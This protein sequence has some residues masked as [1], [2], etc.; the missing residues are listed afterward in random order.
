MEDATQALELT[1]SNSMAGDTPVPTKDL[2]GRTI[3]DF[4]ILRRLGEGGMGQVYLAEQISLQRKVALKVLKKE[5]SADFCSLERFKAE[6]LAVARVTHANIVQVY[7]IDKEA[8]LH[9]MALEYVEGRNLRDYLAKKGTLDAPLAISIMR[10][11]AAALQ[12]A[13]ESGIIHRDIKPENIL[14][15]RKGEVKVADF[16]LSRSFGSDGKALNLTQSGVTMGTPLYMSPEQVQ[17]LPL[18]PRTDIYSFGVTGYH[19]LSGQPPFRSG[20]AFEVALQHVQA[21]PEPL[22]KIRPDLPASLCAIVHKMMAK[23]PDDRYQT[24]R[25]L[26][27][28]LSKLRDTVTGATA[29]L[30]APSLAEIADTSPT[31]PEPPK[32]RTSLDVASDPL[33][34]PQGKNRRWWPWALPAS[35]VVALLAGSALGFFNRRPAAKNDSSLTANMDLGQV[36]IQLSPNKKEQTLR[37]TAKLYGNPGKDQDKIRFGLEVNREL[38]LL[39][40]DQ[41]RWEEADQL[42]QDL[43][44]NGNQ[45]EIYA[46]FGKLG[47][48]IVLGLHSK[49]VESNKLFVDC[50]PLLP[51]K[52]RIKARDFSNH[53]LV[54]LGNPRIRQWIAEALEYNYKNDPT[55]FPRS[56]EPWRK[57]TL[58]ASPRSGKGDKTEK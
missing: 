30:V 55:T 26:L 14:L 27:R 28:D 16:G 1:P 43:M 58:A 9:Y 53:V 32:S 46:Q 20:T 36:E 2:T 39:Y 22:T 25:D 44:K 42:F 5:L 3:G 19:M 11:V 24:S 33:M 8:D 49:P 7:A 10:Q 4:R 6:A 37:D 41:G 35:L 54:V 18:D 48:A 50:L 31:K 56:L 52:Q 17:G 29:S 51:D 13:A 15:T 21:E 40:L 47:H 45:V 38:A 12:R 34:P 57:G 23:K